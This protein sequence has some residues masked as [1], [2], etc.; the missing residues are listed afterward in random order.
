MV[1]PLLGWLHLVPLWEVR[2]RVQRL[3]LGNLLSKFCHMYPDTCNERTRSREIYILKCRM[4]LS[5]QFR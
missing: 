2:M 4:T 1:D 3:W 5:N